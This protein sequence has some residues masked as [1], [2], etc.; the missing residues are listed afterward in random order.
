MN[1]RTYLYQRK[2]KR[3]KRKI[4]GVKA[5]IAYMV[6]TKWKD[7]NQKDMAM[8]ESYLDTMLDWH[9]T[10]AELEEELVMLKLAILVIEKCLKLVKWMIEERNPANV[11]RQYLWQ[12][13]KKAEGM[14]I[15]CS[16]PNVDGYRCEKHRAE[17][18]LRARK[19]QGIPLDTPVSKSKFSEGNKII[20]QR[21][22]AK[23]QNNPRQ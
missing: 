23:H 10:K 8:P 2:V 15:L 20:L 22:M 14:C 13:M 18:W 7:Q 21:E 11:S 19:Y 5:R 16:K 1:I 6:A 4:A 17:N 12:E 3:L 9:A